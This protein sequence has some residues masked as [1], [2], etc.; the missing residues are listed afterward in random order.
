[1][2][3]PCEP[4]MLL[5]FLSKAFFAILGPVDVL[6]NQEKDAMIREHLVRGGKKSDGIVSA[7]SRI[8]FPSTL[9]ARSISALFRFFQNVN[10]L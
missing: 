4:C 3:E 1:M 7:I 5:S 9:H 8:L 2:N 10:R 6:E